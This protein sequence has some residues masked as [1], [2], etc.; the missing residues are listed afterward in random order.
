MNTGRR[1]T[2]ILLE[3]GDE[4]MLLLQEIH[5]ISAATGIQS[6]HEFVKK[7]PMI[8]QLKQGLIDEMEDGQK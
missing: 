4:D 7:Y 2:Y 1:T 8:Q 3:R 5:K 6:I